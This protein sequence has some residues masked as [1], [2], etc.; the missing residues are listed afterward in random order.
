RV[1]RSSLGPRH[2]GRQRPTRIDAN[3]MAKPQML[4]PEHPTYGYRRLQA[5]LRYRLG[6]SVNRKGI[7]RILKAKRWLVHQRTVTPRPRV[8]ASV[9]R[10]NTSDRCEAIDFTHVDCGHD[11]GA[12]L[13]G[14]NRLH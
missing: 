10:T 1:S 11:G 5:L 7:Y 13:V 12:H 8:Q 2:Q 3:L 6:I 4:I 9:S 14:V